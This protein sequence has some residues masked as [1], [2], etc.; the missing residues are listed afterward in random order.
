[1]AIRK[2]D[3][4]KGSKSTFKKLS[5]ACPPR[6]AENSGLSTHPTKEEL[7][8]IFEKANDDMNHLLYHLL[9][10][11]SEIE[12]RT[13]VRSGFEGISGKWCQPAK[14]EARI[15]D[16][17]HDGWVIETVRHQPSRYIFHG[18]FSELPNKTDQKRRI[19]DGW[20]YPCQSAKS[21]LK[22]GG[23]PCKNRIC[24]VRQRDKD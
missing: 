8:K 12:I 24:R 6:K 15:E 19:E 10:I 1:M 11:S 20:V 3:L 18:H 5:K 13:A 4:P 21:I 17:R 9:Y 14:P 7:N 22:R 16:L 2:D 23:K